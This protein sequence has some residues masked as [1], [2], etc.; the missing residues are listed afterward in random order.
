MSTIDYFSFGTTLANMANVELSV[1]CIPPTYLAGGRIP[2]AGSVRRELGSGAT[3]YDGW[4]EWQITFDKLTRVE[5]RGLLIA[6]FGSLTRQ[7]RE[8]YLSW[9]TDVGYIRPLR[10]YVD[11]PRSESFRDFT[12]EVMTGVVFPV[13]SLGVQ[14][15]T[16]TGN[17][18]I[19]TADRMVYADT[20]SGNIT[21][22]LP[23]AD[24]VNPYTAYSIE[25]IASANTVTIAPHAGDSVSPTSLT[26]LGENVDLVSDGVLTW[27]A[28][29][30]G[31]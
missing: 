6:M 2:L 12:P 28:V 20:G 7:S 15:V 26:A 14:S 22:T 10:A 11:R 19:T 4:I 9:Y 13:R 5:Y 16:K 30:D 3:R 29:V 18:T 1:G 23:A 24:S 25:K 8:L 17:Y 31:Q 21:L 27:F